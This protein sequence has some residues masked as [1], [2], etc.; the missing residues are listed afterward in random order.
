MGR[1]SGVKLSERRE[2]FG[3][4]KLCNDP[5]SHVIF[6][7]P[8]DTGLCAKNVSEWTQYEH[9]SPLLIRSGSWFHFKSGEPESTSCKKIESVATP[10]LIRSFI[11]KFATTCS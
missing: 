6:S 9:Y 3:L 11:V 7:K 2:P 8:G 5:W 4:L 10:L 1:F